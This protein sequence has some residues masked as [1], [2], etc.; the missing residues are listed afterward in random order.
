MPRKTKRQQQVS[1]LSRKKGRFTSQKSDITIIEE[2]IEQKKAVEEDLIVKDKN[3]EEW[4]E[5]EINWMEDEINEEWVE[6]ELKEFEEVGKKLINEVLSWDKKATSKIRAVY[7]GDSRTSQWR[8]KKKTIELEEHT[9]GIKKINTFFQPISENVS[10]SSKTPL[11]SQSITPNSPPLIPVDTTMDLHVRL[12]EINQ[13]C[14]VGKSTKE[15]RDIFTYDYI[16][17]LSVRRFIQ[18]LLDGKGKMVASTQI[19]QSM[20][21][22][23]DYMARCIR[24]WGGNFIQTGELPV[25]S[26]GKHMKIKSLLDDEDFSEDCKAWLRQQ[27]PETRSPYNLKMYIEEELF[28]KSTGN[29]KKDTISEKTCRNYMHLWGYRYDERKKGIYYDGHERLDVVEYRK[30]WLERMFMYKKRMKEFDGDM[31]DIVLEPKLE[32]EE[33]ELIQVT[34]DECHFYAND[35]R[36]RIWIGEEE[37]ILRPKHLGRSIIVS[38]FLCSC[39]GLLQLSD[40]QL[41]ENPHIKHKDAYVLRSVQADGYWTLEHMMEQVSFLKFLFFAYTVYTN[42][43]LLFTTKLVHKAVPIFEILH[44]GCIAIFCF[45]QSTNHNAMA[46]DALIATRMNLGSGGVQPK[47]RDGWYINEREEKCIQSMTFPDNH[48]VEKLRGQ[49]KGIKKVLEE[50]NLWPKKKINLV[51]K[52]CSKKN[53]DNDENDEIRLD[54]CARRI[55]SLQ[56]DF[57]EQQSALEEA[58]VRSGHILERYP[59]FHCECNFIERYWGFVKRETRELCSYDYADLLKR[60]PEVLVGVPITTIRKFARKSWRYMDAYNKGLEGRTAEWAVNK[61]KSH[62]RLPENIERIMD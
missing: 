48:P 20:W 38:A 56:P 43:I 30:E 29:I 58:I 49:P 21:N 46:E 12:E 61:Y 14:L 37:D 10:M 47:M 1:E 32:L 28:P 7:T 33:K 16:R 22:K 6:G 57:L 5:G 26:Q 50:R 25:H 9:K 27:T 34:H 36:R 31:L 41:Q 2:E 62:R 3:A 60:I 59:K 24:K 42:L 17:L 51:C 4:M 11:L 53:A 18:Q 55:I 8:Q 19:A 35:R 15:N 45:D 44:P 39:H 13:L 54:C 23:G 40:K 52:K